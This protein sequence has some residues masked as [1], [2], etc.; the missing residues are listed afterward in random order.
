MTAKEHI[1]R[2]WIVLCFMIMT[3]ATILT[4]CSFQYC[5]VPVPI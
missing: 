1:S 3:L 4:C 5:P 2:K